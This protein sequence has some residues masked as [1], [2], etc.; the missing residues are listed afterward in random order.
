MYV[1]KCGVCMYNRATSCGIISFM[2]LSF[3]Y[4]WTADTFFTSIQGQTPLVVGCRE[5][6]R[7]DK[8]ES[9][10]M[11]HTACYSRIHLLGLHSW[12]H[13]CCLFFVRLWNL[14]VRTMVLEDRAVAA[15]VC[16]IKKTIV[17]SVP[18]LQLSDRMCNRNVGESICHR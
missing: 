5:G 14:G 4:W 10:L 16:L 12:S 17:C 6:R 13:N 3:K 8:D 9:C 11:R 1:L 15:L 7:G 2:L 18:D